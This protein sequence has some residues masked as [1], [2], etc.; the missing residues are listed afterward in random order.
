MKDGA[1]I[2]ERA[3]RFSG[4]SSPAL[5]GARDGHRDRRIVDRDRR[6]AVVCLSRVWGSITSVGPP[7]GGFGRMVWVLLSILYAMARAVLGLV[8]LRGRGG[9]AKDVELLVLRHEVA[10]LRRQVLPPRLA[11]QDRLVL[12]ALSR[13]LLRPLWRS[14]I[15]SPATLLRRHRELVARRW[16]YPRTRAWRGG[17]SPTS[18]VTPAMVLRL[19]RENPDGAIAGFRAKRSGSDTGWGRARC[20]GSSPQPV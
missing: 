13:L 2:P 16:T 17:R 6:A 15:V 3:D 14:R 10:V 7:L 11:P 9:A 19:A 20:A 5:S 1:E 4:R 18:A 12:A 8:V